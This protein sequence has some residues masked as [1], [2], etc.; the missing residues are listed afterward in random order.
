MS[1]SG[2]PGSGTMASDFT[3][4][5][6]TGKLPSWTMVMARGN[7]LSRTGSWITTSLC[8]TLS[9]SGSSTSKERLPG[10]IAASADVLVY[11]AM[12]DQ[13]AQVARKA[14]AA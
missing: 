7:L 2:V 12:V 3:W 4:A 10:K 14:P 11:F 8:L 9:A 13:L 1:S 5:T 6:V